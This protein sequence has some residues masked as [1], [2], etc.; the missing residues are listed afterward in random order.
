MPFE[1]MAWIGQFLNAIQFC[2][3]TFFL[4][5]LQLGNKSKATKEIKHT[6]SANAQFVISNNKLYPLWTF[7]PLEF[8]LDSC[9]SIL[10]TGVTF[11]A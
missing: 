2:G 7:N 5:L 6:N 11:L 1:W 4:P 8:S 10:D 3:R 9:L